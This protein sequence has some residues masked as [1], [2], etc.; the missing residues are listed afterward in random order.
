M[1]L[2]G[3]LGVPRQLLEDVVDPGAVLGRPSEV[4]VSSSSWT[5]LS[6]WQQSSNV[7]K[8]WRSRAVPGRCCCLRGRSRS[9]SWSGGSFQS[10]PAPSRRPPLLLDS[11]LVPIARQKDVTNGVLLQ[12]TNK[13]FSTLNDIPDAETMNYDSSTNI[14]ASPSHP[15][16]WGLLPPN[17][18]RWLYEQCFWNL[19]WGSDP[20][21]CRYPAVPRLI[22]AL[23]QSSQHVVMLAFSG[24]ISIFVNA[25][26]QIFRLSSLEHSLNPTSTSFFQTQI[27]QLFTIPRTNLAKY[28]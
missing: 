7:F 3:I 8:T 14:R 13:S 24:T 4:V 11:P 17:L 19:P 15:A 26:P 23:G 28:F 27:T 9:P 22:S 21:R 5:T 16:G 6:L 25:L 10:C 20:P 1:L 12:Q 18:T 2:L